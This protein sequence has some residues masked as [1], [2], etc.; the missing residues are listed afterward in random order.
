M[1]ATIARTLQVLIAL[2]GAYLAALWVVLVVWTYRDAESRSRNVVTQVFSTMLAALFFVPGVLLYMMLRPKE[3]LDSTFQRSLEE[4][5]LLQDLET[6]IAC[7]HCNRAISDEYVVCPH[8]HT[9]L[10]EAC[11]SCGRDIDV[12]WSLCPYCGHEKGAPLT[13]IRPVIQPIERFVQSTQETVVRELP[14]AK[15]IEELEAQAFYRVE[16]PPVPAAIAATSGRAFDR[17]KTREMHRARNMNGRTEP[18]PSPNGNGH[19][20]TAVKDAEP[21]ETEA[22]EVGT[23][24]NGESES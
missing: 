12:R 4:E 1:E 24:S 14:A 2:S 16:G 10:K 23:S 22:V 20:P 19:A 11:V 21:E 8:C 6:N 18:V 13:E 17:R 15:A 5:Y 9:K 7:P 3:T